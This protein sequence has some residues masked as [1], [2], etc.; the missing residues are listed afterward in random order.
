MKK[1]LAA[2][3]IVA[4]LSITSSAMATNVKAKVPQQLCLEFSSFGDYQQ[5]SLKKIGTVT[6]YGSKVTTYAITGSIYNGAYGPVSGSAYVIPGTTTLHASYNGTFGGYGPTACN[7]E[8]F[9][10]LATGVGSWHFVY[11]GTTNRIDSDT[12]YAGE[13]SYFDVPGDKIEGAVYSLT[14]PKQ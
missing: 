11:N 13:C 10:N 1:I 5:L 4:M 12:T 9:L 8:L 3:T 2:I 7:Y 6:D 14:T